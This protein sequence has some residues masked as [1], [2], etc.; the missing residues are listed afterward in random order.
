MIQADIPTELSPLHQKALRRAFLLL[1]NASFVARLADYAGQPV[2]RLLSRMPSAATNRLNDA[3]EAAI[4]NC[5]KLA[6]RR[7]N[8]C[9]PP[10]SRRC[11]PA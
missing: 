8:G 3:I 1:E 4:L 11:W 2:E 7:P 5:L 9:R 10:A 6:I